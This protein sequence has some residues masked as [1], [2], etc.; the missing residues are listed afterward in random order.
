MVTL[1]SDKRYTVDLEHTGLPYP[2]Y[3]VRFCGEYIGHRKNGLPA[4]VFAA[5]EA[6]RRWGCL[7]ITEKTEKAG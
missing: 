1:N 3:V 2:V 5:G 7:V 6:A 4:I